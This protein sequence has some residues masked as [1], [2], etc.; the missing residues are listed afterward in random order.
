MNREWTNGIRLN[1]VVT[2]GEDNWK[3]WHF[4]L[5]ETTPVE[6]VVGRKDGPG[7]DIFLM[8]DAEYSNFQKGRVFRTFLSFK[9][10][11]YYNKVVDLPQ[12]SYRLV[13]SLPQIRDGRSTRATAAV[14]C[15]SIH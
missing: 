4:W 3:A 11:D 10:I 12:G 6:V 1:T 14:R 5:A 7:I 8:D 13:A 15:E 9:N 2:I